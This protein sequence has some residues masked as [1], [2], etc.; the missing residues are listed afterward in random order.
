MATNEWKRTIR[1]SL[2]RPTP[3]THAL[4]GFRSAGLGLP[5]SLLATQVAVVLAALF[6]NVMS[7]RVLGPGGRGELALHLQITYVVGSVILLGRDQSYISLAP[8]HTPLPIVRDEVRRMM[9]LP[10]GLAVAVGVGAG[11]IFGTDAMDTALLATGYVLTISGNLYFKASRAASIVCG[12][13]KQFTCTVVISEIALTLGCLCLYSKNIVRA[14]VWLVVYGF[15]LAAAFL[16]VNGFS[17]HRLSGTRKEL[18]RRSNVLGLRLMPASIADIV[19]LRMDRL[20]LPV[21]AGFQPLGLYVA[22]ATSSELSGIPIRQ[23][24]DA[25]TPT[26]AEQYRDGSLRVFAI[27]WKVFAATLVSNIIVGV[28]GYI[29]LPV[30]FGVQYAASVALIPVL[31]SAMIMYSMSRLGVN[32]ANVTGKSRGATLISGAGMAAAIP[33]YL[34]LIPHYGALGAAYGSLIAYAGSFVAAAV[35]LVEVSHGV[36]AQ[37]H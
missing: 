37:A 22:A 33:S 32:I 6:V 20:I 5:S 14:D 1:K 12:H 19:L 26:W 11:T 3:Y 10:L 18:L 7:S 16:I 17:F 25:R 2:V 35:V 4:R 30:V 34:I 27:A 8:A 21:I 15:F 28:V 31:T 9:R 13:P 24:L 36:T 23:Y 29:M